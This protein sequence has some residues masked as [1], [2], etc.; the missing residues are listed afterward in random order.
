MM[1]IFN[2]FL[3]GA[4]ITMLAA[5]TVHA[6]T[7]VGGMECGVERKVP[8]GALQ[9]Q[10]YNRLNRIYEQIGE[11]EY[12]E[13]YS[14]LE[15]LLGRTRDDYGRATIF[16]AQ[17]HIRAQQERYREAID[18]F[19]KSIEL[20]KMPNS[21]HYDMILQVAQLYY[22]S[23]DF[24]NALDQL[25]LWFC[26]TPDDQKDKDSIWIMKASIHAN[27]DQYREAIEAVDKAIELSD[28]PKENWFAL[29]LGMHFELEEYS[30]A[31]D[32]LKI[33]INMN[34]DKK[35]YWL[36]LSAI[37]SQLDRERDSLG[38]LSMAHR[39][40]L[41]DKETEYMQLA[42]LQQ[43]FGFPRKAA[44]VMEE[45]L[46]KG[47]VKDTRRNWEMVG[48]AWYESRELDKALVAYEKAGAQSDDGKIDFQRASILTD[49]ERW[50]ESEE[51]LTRALELG[52]LTE[53]QMGN[54]YLLL[55][56]ARFNQENNNGAVEAFTKARDYDRS[57]RAANEWINHIRK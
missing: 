42:G 46:E 45:G 36:Q 20:D 22:A 52:G 28:D 1:K 48:G 18:L 51:A 47:V 44:E 26:I 35:D 54:A 29:K 25:D 23:E 40:G 41:F 15:K 37:Y 50:Q 33:L 16:Q 8:A 38:V 57:R 11:E 32:V 6:Q 53:S 55:G 27:I 31:A 3:L 19:N 17:G 7:S 56:M 21:Q 12:D 2:T 30:E 14:E 43:Q 24:N 39:R 5:G 9:E 49:Q 10:T 13:A 4:A 34:P